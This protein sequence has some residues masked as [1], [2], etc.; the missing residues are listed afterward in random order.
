MPFKCQK[1]QIYFCFSKMKAEWERLTEAIILKMYFQN[2]SYR[3]IS[4]V[5]QEIATE[6]VDDNWA[7][8]QVMAWYHQAT[9]H[10]LSPCCH[11]SVTW[12]GI[13]RPQWVNITFMFPSQFF[14]KTFSDFLSN[15]SIC[16]N[17]TNTSI[18]IGYKVWHSHSGSFK[19]SHCMTRFATRPKHWDNGAC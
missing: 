11:R 19:H 9:S 10:Y 7:L 18:T 1:L 5:S 3:L 17:V 13:T 4:W 12:Y 6:L 15:I 16:Y 8:V 14:K 2:S